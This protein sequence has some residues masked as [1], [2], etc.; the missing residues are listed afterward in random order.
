MRAV[1]RATALQS[2]RFDGPLGPSEQRVPAIRAPG[3]LIVHF[4]PEALG[5]DGLYDSDFLPEPDGQAGTADCGLCAIDHVALGLGHDQLDTWVLFCR[6]VLDLQAGDS[7][8]LADPFGLVRSCG[9]ADAG[10]NVRLVLNVSTSRRA[11]TARAPGAAGAVVQHIAL[12]SADIFASVDRLRGAGVAFVPISPNYYD[13]LPTRFDLAPG[14]VARLRAS[15]V[16]F[17]RSPQGDYFHIYGESV[18][19]RFFFE[20]VQ[21]TGRYDGYGAVNA[22]AR[23]ASQAQ[24]ATAA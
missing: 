12:D 9:V 22:P 3:G 7:L 19:G 4:V 2:A 11:G 8:E 14:Q 21:R 20:I 6:A 1:N 13:D 23:M 5:A 15:G 24:S 16:L 10:R 18:A 17:D